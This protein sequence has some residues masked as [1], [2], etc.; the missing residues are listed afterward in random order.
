MA[1]MSPGA[2]LRELQQAQAGLKKARSLL[3]QV[4]GNPRTLAA[5]FVAGW[6]TLTQAHRV[7]ASIP[8]DSVDDDVLTKQ[9]ALQRYATALLVRL[10]RLKRNERADAGEADV[11]AEFAD[12]DGEE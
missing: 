12:D 7:M 10:R 2:V 3:K 8:H 5:V 1:G 6:E 9:L 4:K 11:D